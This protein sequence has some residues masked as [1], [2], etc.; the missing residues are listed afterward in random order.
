MFRVAVRRGL[1]I[2]LLSCITGFVIA[3]TPVLLG[4]S[5]NVVRGCDFIVYD[6]GGAGAGYG[7]NRNDILTI[8]SSD[9]NA[10]GVVVSI[11]V[12]AFNVHPSDTLYIYDAATADPL[13]LMAALN[14]S[15]IRAYTSANIVFSASVANSTGA[16]TLKFVSD[17]ANAG[18]GFVMTTSCSAP[19]QQVRFE[20]DSVLSSHY[21]R[22]EEDGYSYINVCGNESIHMVAHGVFPEND[23]HYHQSNENS[24]FIWDMGFESFE[25]PGVNT[26]DYQFIPGRGYDVSFNISDVNGCQSTMPISFRVRTS[27]NPIKGLSRIGPFCSGDEMDVTFGPTSNETVQISDSMDSQQDAA[28]TVKDTIFLPDGVN[29]GNG[30]AYQS[31]VKFTSFTSNSRITS[32]DDILYVRIKMEHS[33]V[34][35]LYIELTCPEQQ[36]VKILNKYGTS[37]S[38]ACAASIPQPWGWQQATNVSHNA[39]FGIVGSGNNSAEKCDPSFN[40]IGEPWNYCWSENTNPA[41]GYSYARG[42]KRVYENVNIHNGRIDS[43]NMA[44]MTQVYRP[45]QSF[46]QLVG[47]SLN[48]TWTITVID[49]W[50]GDNG[51]ISEWELALDSTLLPETWEYSVHTD[52]TYV[53]GP[54]AYDHHIRFVQ[55]GQVP[56]TFH[57]TDDFGC[58]YD[59]VYYVS[60]LQ[61]PE[62]H[63]GEDIG[64]CY[65]DKAVISVD[66]LPYGMT[67]VWNTGD[68]TP[69]ITVMS[70]GDYIVDLGYFNPTVNKTCHGKDTIHVSS[71]ER[72][73]ADFNLPVTGGCAPLSLKMEN[74]SY[75]EEAQYE[76]M[77]LDSTGALRYSSNLKEPTF[78]ITEQGTFTVMLVITTFDGCP[79]TLFKWNSLDVSIQPIA[80]FAPD[81][82]IS[83]LAENDGLVNFINYSDTSILLMPGTTFYWNFGDGEMD[84]T[85]VAPEHTYGQW[86]DYD[87]TLHIETDAGCTSEIT[88]TVVIEQDLVFPN[89]IT[90]NGDGINDVFAI[91]NL[92]TSLHADDPDGYRNNKL[93]I[94]DR[95]GKRVYEAKNYDTFSRDGQIQLGSKVFDGSGVSDG[96][97]YF[98]FYYKGKAKTVTYNGS[99]TIIR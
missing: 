97:Y 49:G 30:C 41:Y 80:E 38:A 23:Q 60:V 69:Q 15:L 6:N 68:E 95:W 67:C 71:L 78:V 76:W 56:Y 89:V 45:D 1:W 51:Y 13:S 25:T 22:V 57:V 98:S 21:P 20:L 85:N 88:H 44:A 47:C 26:L 99:L 12:S 39:H 84:S 16:I 90:P 42:N 96:V 63:L 74:L 43:T 86:G 93:E 14:D 11:D 92:N 3:Q 53:T 50:S 31:P 58:D 2:L 10:V 73:T 36:S 32:A 75:P 72:P 46:S 66:T 54:G 64:L 82:E 24:T 83:M 5:V 35:D 8:Y 81:P 48:G 52:S 27:K 34:G 65:G 70:A 37:G 28:L 77:I 17:A 61:S 7:H 33:Y 62:P 87:V 4:G 79:D 94:F 29:C 55:A 9:A 19:C 40:P 91:E 18:S 59:T